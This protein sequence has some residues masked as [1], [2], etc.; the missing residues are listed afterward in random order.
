[1]PTVLC[2]EAYQNAVS[3]PAFSGCE[4]W[5]ASS[6]PS[7][8]GKQ[9][10]LR[11]VPLIKMAHAPA[12]T[13]AAKDVGM[14]ANTT[15]KLLLLLLCRESNVIKQPKSAFLGFLFAVSADADRGA[16]KGDP[17]PNLIHITV[18]VCMPEATFFASAFHF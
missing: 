6:S 17:P 2:N 9:N 4:G 14:R 16:A 3:H 12:L 5:W 15:K 18:A 8:P 13:P 1:M 10:G 7:M 11:S